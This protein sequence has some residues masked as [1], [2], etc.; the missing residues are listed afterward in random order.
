MKLKNDQKQH[1]MAEHFTGAQL[2]SWCIGL[3]VCS[4]CGRLVGLLFSWSFG[5]MFSWLVD[6]M[7]V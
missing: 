7:D 6:S 4:F 5:W 1:V 3:S 2:R